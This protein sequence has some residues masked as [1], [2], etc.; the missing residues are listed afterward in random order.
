MTR[1]NTNISIHFA[2]AATC[3]ASARVLTGPAGTRNAHTLA[4]GS[5]R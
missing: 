5:A 1:T 4:P 3:A 2:V